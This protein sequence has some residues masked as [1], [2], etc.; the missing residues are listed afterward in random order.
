MGGPARRKRIRRWVTREPGAD[1]AWLWSP[2]ER[3]RRRNLFGGSWMWWGTTPHHVYNFRYLTGDDLREYA[4]NV[5]TDRP[6]LVEF[7]A[8]VVRDGSDS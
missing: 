8:R 2:E 3:P 6:I 5:P 1:E 7:S 4:L